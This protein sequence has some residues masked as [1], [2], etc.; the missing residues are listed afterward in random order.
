MD[1]EK[2]TKLEQTIVLGLVVIFA[3]VFIQGPLKSFGLFGSAGGGTRGPTAASMGATPVEVHSVSGLLR[4]GWQKVDDQVR[5]VVG[6]PAP[7]PS[8]PPAAAY[9]AFDVRDPLKSFLPRPALSTTGTSGAASETP[10]ATRPP[11]PPQLQVEGLLWGG[12]RPQAIIN[13]RVYGVA[14]TVNGVKITG[15]NGSGVTI[16]YLGKPVVYPTAMLQ[17][18]QGQGGWIRQ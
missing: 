13:G 15:I 14:D 16:D 11:P 4:E 10:E 5:A 18:Q 3:A 12:T 7:P 8:V 17:Q 1:A 9:T 6:K 2:K